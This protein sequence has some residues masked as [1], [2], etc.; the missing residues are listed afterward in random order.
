[1]AHFLD[2]HKIYLNNSNWPASCFA[3]E[4]FVNPRN[5]STRR[6]MR[7]ALGCL[8]KYPTNSKGFAVTVSG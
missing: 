1:M 3:K 8:Q 5:I 7:I 2:L 6:K 4:F